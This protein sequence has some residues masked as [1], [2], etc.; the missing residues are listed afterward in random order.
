MSGFWEP[1]VEDE[2]VRWPRFDQAG[3]EVVLRRED[4]IHPLISGNKFR[5]LKYNLLQAKDLGCKA[6]LTLG[7]AHSNHIVAVAALAR[8]QG[9]TSEGWIRGDELA[10]DSNDTLRQAAA[11]GMRL[12]FVSRGL[13]SVLRTS[14]WEE[15]RAGLWPTSEFRDELDI[16]CT[17]LHE[18]LPRLYF[19][20]EGGTNRLAVVGCREILRLDDEVFD[21]ICCAVGTGGTMAG[22]VEGAGG[23]SLVQGF[24]ALLGTTDLRRDIAKFTSKTN[25]ELTDEFALGGY[26]RVTDELVD[27]INRF[28]A[29]GNALLDPIYTGKMLLG[30]DYMAARGD[31]ERGSRILVIHTGGLQGIGG[32]NRQRRRLGRPE[33]VV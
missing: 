4:R 31:W 28:R 11:L 7:G 16:L 1:N 32:I 17:P 22:L 13:Y 18:T 20:P 8:E 29:A 25:W 33:I 26:G 2:V 3:W 21:R 12:R 10:P 24:S 6:L 30:L 23:H 19:L 15:I 5:K 14:S 9:L 27:W